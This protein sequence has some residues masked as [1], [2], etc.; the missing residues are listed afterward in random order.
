MGGA[1]IAMLYPVVDIAGINRVSKRILANAADAIAGMAGGAS[2]TLADDAADRPLVAATMFG[3]T[4]PCVTAARERLEDLGYEVLVFHATGTGGRSM[5]ALVR[6]GTVAGVL[7]VDHDRARRR[8][9]RWCDVGRARSG[10]RLP[11][12]GR[13]RRSSR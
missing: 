13:S 1:D 9:R 2:R 5:E 10:S 11:A 8:A 12:H 6:S 4:T 3:V 7:D